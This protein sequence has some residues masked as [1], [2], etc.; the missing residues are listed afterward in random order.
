MKL[1]TKELEKIIP[2]LYS[3]EDEKDPMV[4]IKYFSILNHWSW[5]A[6]EYSREKKLFF[7]YVVG[8]FPEWGYFSLDEFEDINKAKSFPAIERDLWFKPV[9]FS[10]IKGL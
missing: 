9:R 6:T 7:G 4:Y 8:D 1:I 3:Q 10:Q 2:D 5:Y